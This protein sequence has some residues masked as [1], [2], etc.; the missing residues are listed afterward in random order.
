MGEVRDSSWRLLTVVTSLRSYDL[1]EMDKA[2]RDVFPVN[3]ES[4]Q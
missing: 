4:D 2:E 1:G 3:G